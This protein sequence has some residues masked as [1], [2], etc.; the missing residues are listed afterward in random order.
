MDATVVETVSGL[1]MGVIRGLITIL[2]MA[3]YFGI[4]WWAYRRG[5]RERFET[6]ALM[7][8]VDE[9]DAPA[10]QVESEEKDQ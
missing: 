4:F 7:P 9:G 6:D 2:T 10:G 3:A 1:D 5:N 8:F